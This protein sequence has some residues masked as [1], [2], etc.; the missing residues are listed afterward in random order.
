MHEPREYM[1]VAYVE[2][3]VWP[4]DVRRH[5]RGEVAPVL[6][7]VAAVDDVDHPL[8][9]RITLVGGMWRTVV[10]HGLVDRVGGLIRENAR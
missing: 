9:V 4:E 3:V 5:Y 6:L 7:L 8:R 2:V 10:D 1:A